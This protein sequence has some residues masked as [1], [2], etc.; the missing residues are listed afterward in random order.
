[1]NSP[2][3]ETLS[4]N[5]LAFTDFHG[6]H[7][8]YGRAKELIA[9]GKPDFVIVAGDIVNRDPNRAKQFLFDLASAGS[10][11]YFVP[12]NMDSDELRN[13]PGGENVYALHGRCENTETVTLIG[14]GGSPHGPFRTI[15]EYSEEEASE[16][17]EA[18][19][20]SYHG[21]QLIFVS[22]CPPMNTKLDQVTSGAHVGS[23]AVREFVERRQPIL[24]VSGH[25]HE[26]QGIDTIGPSLLVNTGPAQLGHYAKITLGND[27]AVKFEKIL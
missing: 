11:V 25:V 18:A 27:V 20:K 13:W 5:I 2:N 24:V 9:N 10:P 21:G 3:A 16:L 1:M 23:T 19:A 12:G 22:H 14:L 26:A 6:N 15:F 7:E 17:V 4:L 8:A